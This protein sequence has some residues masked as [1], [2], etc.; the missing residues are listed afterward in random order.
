M[1]GR[2]RNFV[3]DLPLVLPE[4]FELNGVDSL[5]TILRMDN[6]PDLV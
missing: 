3:E 2:A 4:D 6:R 5:L 1:R